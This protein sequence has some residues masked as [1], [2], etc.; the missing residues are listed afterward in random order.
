MAV[1]EE[2]AWYTWSDYWRQ[3][4]AA[5]IGLTQARYIPLVN[6]AFVKFISVLVDCWLH[7]LKKKRQKNHIFLQKDLVVGPS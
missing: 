3:D 5:R 1:E 7:Q 2:W 6:A 4:A